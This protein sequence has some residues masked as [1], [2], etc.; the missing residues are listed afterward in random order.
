MTRL[1]E[2]IELLCVKFTN[3]PLDKSNGWWSPLNE[4]I[5]LR[6]QI[7][8]PKSQKYLE[9]KEVTLAIKSVIECIDYVFVKVYKK[10]LPSATLELQ[11]SLDF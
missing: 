11:S 2:K 10:G 9:I 7:V 8:H 1:V 5:K 4:S 6:N 3:E